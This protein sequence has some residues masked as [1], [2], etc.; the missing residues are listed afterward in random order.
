MRDASLRILMRLTALATCNSR[1]ATLSEHVQVSEAAFFATAF[2][3]V[4]VVVV[5]AVFF[6]AAMSFSFV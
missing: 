4:F 2:F 3:G 1:S 6:F 5:V